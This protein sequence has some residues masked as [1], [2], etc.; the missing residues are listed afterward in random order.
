MKPAL[1][2]ERAV[3]LGFA[4][5]GRPAPPFGTLSKTLRFAAR[6]ATIATGGTPTVVA[7]R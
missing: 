4:P 3:R 7:V 5:R 6:A 1:V 2:A